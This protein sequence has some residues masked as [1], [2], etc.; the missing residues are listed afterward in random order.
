MAEFRAAR[1]RERGGDQVAE[2]WLEVGGDRL[3]PRDSAG[4]ASPWRAGD[5]VRLGVRWALD[6]PLRPVQQGLAYPGRVADRTVA[7][8]FGGDWA[9]LRLLTGLP[10]TGAELGG[11]PARQRHMLVLS[12][13][14]VPVAVDSTIDAERARVFVR[15]RLRDP[16]TGAERALPAFP[17]YAPA[18]RGLRGGDEQA[19][20]GRGTRGQ[21]TGERGQ[22]DDH[23]WGEGDRV[24]VSLRGGAGSRNPWTRLLRWW[25]GGGR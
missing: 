12:V 17:P 5:A 21:G 23:G 1:A 14:T 4:T 18:L 15:V 11:S 8:S 16:V 13:P 3:T 7:W 24:A 19:M 2:W 10:S 22:R 25:T 20:R 9:L 6:S